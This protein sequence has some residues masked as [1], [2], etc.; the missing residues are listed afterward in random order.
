MKVSD[1]H[2]EYPVKTL[3][4]VAVNY[5]DQYVIHIKFNDSTSKNKDFGNF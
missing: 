4:V 1:L 2:I 5:L 3:K